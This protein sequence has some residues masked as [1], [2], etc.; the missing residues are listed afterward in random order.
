MKTKIRVNIQL[1]IV[2]RK[3]SLIKSFVFSSF[4]ILY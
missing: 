3:E 4:F 1:K 2:D